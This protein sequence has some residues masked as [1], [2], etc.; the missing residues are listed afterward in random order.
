YGLIYGMH[1]GI[2]TARKDMAVLMTLNQNGQAITLANQ[3]INRNVVDG[4]SLAKLVKNEPRQSNQYTFANTFPTGTHAMWLNYWLAAHDINPMR[5]V[6]VVTIPP[7]QM[8]ANMALGDV[9]GFCAGEPWNHW[10][11][12][13]NVGFTAVT[14]QRIWPGHPEKVL[15]VSADFIH[16]FPNTA[17]AVTAAV[18]EASRWI[19]N[20]EANKLQACEII[21][22]KAYINTSVNVIIPRMLGHYPSG[23]GTTRVD[24][25]CLKFHQDGAVN[26]PYLSDG[27][28]FLTQYKR[29]GLLKEHPDYLA[30]ASAINQVD[31]YREAATL[32]G[33]SAPAEPM[34][35]AVLIDGVTW[36]GS[37]PRA[38][39][40]AFDIRHPDAFSVAA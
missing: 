10:A 7:P 37:A 24:L 15:G 27:M 3:L 2:G 17:R 14:S 6:S 1:L 38:Y 11:V 25:D 4:R 22:G 26:F 9:V 12:A 36:D 5:D 21:A 33:V 30:V 18:L 39:A 35:S 32:A 29:W 31:L 23:S 40:N 34:R 8:V 28:W 16:R 20:S 19:D 13:D